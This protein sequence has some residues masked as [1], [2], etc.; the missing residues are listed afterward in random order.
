MMETFRGML[1]RVCGAMKQEG[2]GDW[3]KHACEGLSNA[4]CSFGTIRAN[5]SRWMRLA[6]RVVFIGR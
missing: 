6:G 4:Y 5:K 1:R 2:K 3:T